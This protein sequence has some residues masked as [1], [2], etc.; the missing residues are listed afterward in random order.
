MQAGAAEIKIGSLT[1]KLEE[2]DHVGIPSGMEAQ[3]ASKGT[4]AVVFLDAFLRD[5]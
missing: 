3:I 1:A 4:R 5:V 2:H